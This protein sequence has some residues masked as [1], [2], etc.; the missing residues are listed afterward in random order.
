MD[1]NKLSQHI[2]RTKDNPPLRTVKKIGVKVCQKIYFEI[3]K[4]NDM[5]F[6]SHVNAEHPGLI[7]EHHIDISLLSNAEIDT[8][9]AEYLCGM[10]LSHKYQILGSGWVK[11][12]YDYIPL[13]IEGNKYKMSINIDTIDRHGKWIGKV[14]RRA[15]LK[16]AQ[17]IWQMIDADYS[18]IDWQVD[19]KS[20]YRWDA[21]KWFKDQPNAPVPGADIK[22]PWELSRLQHLPQLAVIAVIM[23]DKANILIKEFKNQVLDFIAMNP[24][25]MGVAWT[26]TMDVAI[27]AAN[28]LV[29][30]DIFYQIDSEN[31][32]HNSFKEI[33]YRSIYEHGLH[34]LSNLEWSESFT[35]NHYLANICGMV[36]VSSY[37]ER[38]EITDAWFAF[39][40]Q[41]LIEEFDK[42]FLSD[43]TNFE[44]STCYH[45]LS[46]EMITYATAIIYGINDD[47][48]R[49]LYDYN[50]RLIK[51]LSPNIVNKYN[52]GTGPFFE[53][54][55]LERLLKAIYFIIDV[56]KPNGE[57][58]QIG[59]NDSGRFINLFPRGN[60]ID[61]EQAI[62]K[63]KNLTNFDSIYSRDTDYFDENDLNHYSLVSA[64]AALFD[65]SLF[66]DYECNKDVEYCFIKSIIKKK[67]FKINYEHKNKNIVIN[68]NFDKANLSYYKQSVIS[69]ADYQ[70]GYYLDL[71]KL[72]RTD[73]TDFGI[74]IFKTDKFYFLIYT[75]QNGQNG[76]G[77][78]SHNDR[79]SFELFIKD[80]DIV[81]DPGTY[82]YTALPEKRN[83]FRS[84]FAHSTIIVE[85]REQNRFLSLF[86][87]ENACNC[88]IHV[89]EERLIYCEANYGDIRHIRNVAFFRD[90]IRIEDYCNKP[91][92]F[93]IGRNAF[94]S[95]GYGKLII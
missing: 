83:M 87:M 51:R 36:F 63:Y 81:R 9:I 2:Q 90:C 80:K 49:A 24:P 25:R 69:F 34:I 53:S 59:D 19:Y 26:C 60:I 66:S 82:L 64:G 3:R 18:P 38:T 78:H 23:K 14:L 72:E 54:K 93:S 75:G 77:G 95:N 74:Y 41:E 21:K 31:L 47:K 37:I 67:I 48:R 65:S 16:E 71:S 61:I 27:R 40:V 8:N 55:Y 20:G 17:R 70:A 84:V 6:D 68:N 11:A 52:L 62:K 76:L 22:I 46:T 86:S 35:A 10:Y 45:R 30:Y 94:Y 85:N 88:K 32:L 56:T 4:I 43:G 15:S 79:L 1:F 13:G 58:C 91:F 57:V 39:S 5:V 73:Y 92:S 89:F 7:K 12:G 33:F 44:G 42:Q 28:L 50:Y 29:A